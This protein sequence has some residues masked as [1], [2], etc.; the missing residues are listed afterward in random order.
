MKKFIK[1]ILSFKVLRVKNRGKNC[2]IHP[3]ADLTINNNLYLG[4]NCIIRKGAKIALDGSMQLEKNNLINTDVNIYIKSGK[5]Y[6]GENSYF[7]N[8][9]TVIGIGDITIGKDVMIGPNSV[10]ISGNHNYKDSIPYIKQGEI[11]MEL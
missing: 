1:T 10:L 6:M 8:N 9:C 4:D 3:Q 11:P 5:L 7:N 2:F